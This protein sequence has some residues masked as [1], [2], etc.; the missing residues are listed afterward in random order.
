[1]RLQIHV[2]LL[3]LHI[4]NL[5]GGINLSTDKKFTEKKTKRC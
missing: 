2:N 3:M 4:I 1:M 5:P